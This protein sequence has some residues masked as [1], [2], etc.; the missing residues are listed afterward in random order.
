MDPFTQYPENYCWEKF[1]HYG[2]SMVTLLLSHY[3][4]RYC[5]RAFL[6]VLVSS[7]SNTDTF[8]FRLGP[9]T[10]RQYNSQNIGCNE[11]IILFTKAQ[12]LWPHQLASPSGKAM[13]LP[14][15]TVCPGQHQQPFLLI[16]CSPLHNLVHFTPMQQS[17]WH[18]VY[19][20]WNRSAF[21]TFWCCCWFLFWQSSG[22]L[23]SPISFCQ[24]LSIHLRFQDFKL[25]PLLW[26]ESVKTY[27]YSNERFCW[28][29][30]KENLLQGPI[31]P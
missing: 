20:L 22:P 31:Y 21:S 24:P 2:R 28:G 5:F 12:Y 15:A 1:R 23:Q 25:R 29:K 3:P 8:F 16:W 13:T 6:L 17:N 9:N 30:N 10:R 4:A 7:S 11:S 19:Q 26:L 18:K 27:I 14:F